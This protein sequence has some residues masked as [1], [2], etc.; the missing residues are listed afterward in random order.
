MLL[1]TDRRTSTVKKLGREL[2]KRQ[3]FH[4]WKIQAFCNAILLVHYYDLQLLTTESG[5][6]YRN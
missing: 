3:R 6:H 4:P 2:D 5:K 1:K